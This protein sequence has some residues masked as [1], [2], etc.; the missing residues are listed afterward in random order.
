M[1]Y[2]N[3][4]YAHFKIGGGWKRMIVIECT[5]AHFIIR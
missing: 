1:I 5:N 4:D 2:D 3:I